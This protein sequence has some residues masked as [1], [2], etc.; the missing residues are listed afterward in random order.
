MCP[1]SVHCRVKLDS[2]FHCTRSNV[3]F[4]STRFFTVFYVSF[5]Q[6][7]II[8]GL[9]LNVWIWISTGHPCVYMYSWLHVHTAQNCIKLDSRR[10]LRNVRFYRVN[11]GT[12]A[13]FQIQFL[14]HK[15]NRLGLKYKN[16]SGNFTQERIAIQSENRVE[17]KDVRVSCG[18]NA[19]FIDVKPGGVAA[20]LQTVQD[21]EYH[22]QPHVVTGSSVNPC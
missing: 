15:E 3:E 12:S 1:L 9:F 13:Y 6:A 18:H 2:A 21:C 11:R 10:T 5:S 7:P 17:H 20:H 22:G 19:E 4:K 16:R 8:Q 14:P